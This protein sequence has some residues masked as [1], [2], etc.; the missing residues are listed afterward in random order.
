MTPD[1]QEEDEIL[2]LQGEGVT[3]TTTDGVRDVAGVEA[4]LPQEEITEDVCTGLLPP[5]GPGGGV[6]FPHLQRGRVVVVHLPIT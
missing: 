6:L 4:E 5:G 2:F 3:Q 1:L